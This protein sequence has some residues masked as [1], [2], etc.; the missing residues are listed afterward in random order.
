MK[1]D[2]D[3]VILDARTRK[4]I[5]GRSRRHRCSLDLPAVASAHRSRE[6]VTAAVEVLGLLNLDQPQ[7]R[8]V[9]QGCRLERL[10]GASWA[11]FCAASLSSSS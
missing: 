1:Y 11:S 7:V 3:L 2:N 8:F 4:M 10:A 9:D 6:D 5:L